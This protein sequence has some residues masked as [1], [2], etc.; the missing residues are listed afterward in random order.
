MCHFWKVVW[1][2]LTDAF[3]SLSSS[4]YDHCEGEQGKLHGFY[5]LKQKMSQCVFCVCAND[6]RSSTFFVFS[7]FFKLILLELIYR[8]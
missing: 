2:C 3:L 1:Q 4:K 6:Y 7:F 5:V 8:N